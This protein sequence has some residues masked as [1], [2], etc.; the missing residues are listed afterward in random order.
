MADEHDQSPELN[1]GAVGPEEDPAPWLGDLPYAYKVAE[2]ERLKAAGYAKDAEVEVV[3][4]DDVDADDVPDVTR[5][6]SGETDPDYD[7]VG[8]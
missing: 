6:L 3:N 8:D 5:D 1:P 2:A 4:P 7:E